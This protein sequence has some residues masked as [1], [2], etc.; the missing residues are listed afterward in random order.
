[1]GS[2]KGVVVPSLNSASVIGVSLS[3]CWRLRLRRG[4]HAPCARGVTLPL[5][6]PD[7]FQLGRLPLFGG[8]PDCTRLEVKGAL[9]GLSSR[10][11]LCSGSSSCSWSLRN[12]NWRVLDKNATDDARSSC[13]LLWRMRPQPHD[14]LPH[15]LEIRGRA[16]DKSITCVDKATEFQRVNARVVAKFLL[17]HSIRFPERAELR[18]VGLSED[19]L[20]HLQQRAMGLH[21]DGTPQILPCDLERTQDRDVQG[22]ARVVIFKAVPQTDILVTALAVP[23]VVGQQHLSTTLRHTPFGRCARSRTGLHCANCTSPSVA[24]VGLKSVMCIAELS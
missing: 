6:P 11:G 12:W 19:V 23:S 14:H 7:L 10:S 4:R 5:A 21:E 24:R 1:M 9:Y 3:L 15:W 22:H 18:F 8:F 17:H 16:T 13:N 2:V 20:E